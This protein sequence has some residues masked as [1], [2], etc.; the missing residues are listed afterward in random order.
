MHSVDPVPKGPG[1]PAGLSEPIVL[2]G[3]EKLY[4][5]MQAVA[6]ISLELAAGEAVSIVGPSGCGKSTLMRLIAG[7]D[8]VTGGQIRIGSRPVTGPIADMGIVFQRDL[9]LDWRS[10]L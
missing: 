8:D 10:V 4:G 9:L 7:L 2:E 6:P 3:V 1:K 5:R